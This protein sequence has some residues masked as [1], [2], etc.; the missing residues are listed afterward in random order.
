MKK[1]VGNHWAKQS[2]AVSYIIISNAPLQATKDKMQEKITAKL[3]HQASDLYA[4]TLSSFQ[5]PS[6]KPQWEK[7]W[8]PIV[9]AK[10]SLF[11]ALAE[12]SQA[13]VA[14]D[15]Q[16]YGE[17]IARLK[18]SVSCLEDAGKRGEGFYDLKGILARVKAKLE[19]ELKDNKLIY[20]DPVPEYATIEPVG[21]AALAKVTAVTIYI[22]CNLV[23]G[24]QFSEYN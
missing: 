6:V 4:D 12:E 11:L 14:L 16:C 2:N 13:K 15:N 21:K 1:K 3:A 9:S 17:S 7:E 23:K 24:T 8:V 20:S 19:K 22:R 5:Q 10:Q 18:K